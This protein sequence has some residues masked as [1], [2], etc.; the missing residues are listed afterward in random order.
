MLVYNPPPTQASV[1]ST[2]LLPGELSPTGKRL[3]S[4]WRK[5]P[6]LGHV[7]PRCDGRVDGEEE[8]PNRVVLAK[9][10]VEEMRRLRLEDPVSNSL[11]SLSKR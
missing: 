1:R 2:T 3:P 10:V 9:E 7:A 4:G 11:R 5:V 6:G 8:R